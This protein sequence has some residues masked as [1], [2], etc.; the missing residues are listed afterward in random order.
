MGSRCRVSRRDR[1]KGSVFRCHRHFGGQIRAW[2]IAEQPVSNQANKW[3]YARRRQ[4]TPFHF[5]CFF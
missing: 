2:I 3:A 5:D 1:T 4:K